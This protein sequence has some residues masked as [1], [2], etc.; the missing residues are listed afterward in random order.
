[1]SIMGY[2]AKK[3]LID[4]RL[5]KREIAILCMLQQG[6]SDETICKKLVFTP[7]GYKAQMNLVL[8]KLGLPCIF[9]LLQW[10]E[11]VEIEMPTFES[12]VDEELEE[13]LKALEQYRV[14]TGK[15]FLYERDRLVV[16]KA[17]GYR[18]E[19]K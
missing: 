13:F 19:S 15:H 18:K 17:L 1:M 12:D 9:N 6:A 16:L 7:E 5:T 10:I 8:Y 2:R 4:T 3:V 11:K 14:Q